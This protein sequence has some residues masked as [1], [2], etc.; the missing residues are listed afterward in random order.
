MSSR[1]MTNSALVDLQFLIGFYKSEV[2]KKP[3]CLASRAL[4]AR[5]RAKLLEIKNER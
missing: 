2:C 1:K 5:S 4:L 3:S